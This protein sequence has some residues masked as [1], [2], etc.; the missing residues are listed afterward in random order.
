M[1]PVFSISI[2]HSLYIIIY[3]YIVIFYNFYDYLQ[4]PI[5]VYNRDTCTILYIPILNGYLKGQGIV[6]SAMAVAPFTSA[7]FFAWSYLVRG[8]A[9]LLGRD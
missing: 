6:E 4:L 5:T 3:I 9:Q 1:Y 8:E 2:L 7:S